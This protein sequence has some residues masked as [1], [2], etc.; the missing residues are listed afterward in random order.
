[1]QPQGPIRII[2]GDQ[3]NRCAQAQVK[4]PA[5]LRESVAM[6]NVRQ[7]INEL[8]RKWEVEMGIFRYDCS[9]FPW[10][11]RNEAYRTARMAFEDHEN[12]PNRVA[13]AVLA[14]Y[15]SMLPEALRLER[16]RLETLAR[17]LK[18]ARQAEKV[19]DHKT[20]AKL[21]AAAD[22][23]PL[24]EELAECC[25][26]ALARYMPDRKVQVGAAAF[27]KLLGQGEKA[28]MQSE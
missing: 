10:L 18:Y 13:R 19:G 1:M 15:Q 5:L 21:R 9:E 4:R 28:L 6:S 14:F 7:M 11:M 27:D 8:R 25:R 24:T 26:R 22:D 3:P 23:M 20:A 17:R 16:L 2:E 12:G